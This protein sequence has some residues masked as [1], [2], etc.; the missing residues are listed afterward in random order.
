M[1]ARLIFQGV[2]NGEHTLGSEFLKRKVAVCKFSR[3][4]SIIA[5]LTIT[6]STNFTKFGSWN[7]YKM[8]QSAINKLILINDNISNR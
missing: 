7:T 4:F 6:V 3:K 1:F 2:C 8:K 5:R